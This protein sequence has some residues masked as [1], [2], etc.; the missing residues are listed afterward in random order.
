[1][2]GRLDGFDGRVTEGFD[3]R[4]EVRV[5]GRETLGREEG[6]ES[7]GLV[8]VRVEGRET[9]GREEGR[10]TLGRVVVRVEGRETLGREEGR[11]I[12]EGALDLDAG[13]ADRLG[14]GRLADRPAEALRP[15]PPPPKPRA[16]ASLANRERQA[17]WTMRTWDRYFMGTGGWGFWGG[18]DRVPMSGRWVGSVYS[19][20]FQEDTIEPIVNRFPDRFGFRA[21]RSIS[22]R[23]PGIP[24]CGC[25]GWRFT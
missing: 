25:P 11:E 14:L 3:G 15:P 23:F 20:R 7:L 8:E 17:I 16:M 21:I 10:E 18:A 5:D 13:R 24:A 6:R 22:W 4:G 2:D 12:R 9:L 1:M 19:I